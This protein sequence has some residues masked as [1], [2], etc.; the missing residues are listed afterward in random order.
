[1][2]RHVLRRGVEANVGPVLIAAGDREIADALAAE[3]N[4]V[5]TNPNL[6]SGSDRSFAA[7]LHFDPDGSYDVIVNL[8][9]DMPTISPVLLHKAISVLDDPEIDIVTL[10]TPIADVT[11]ADRAAVVKVAMEPTARDSVIG[12]A[13]YFSRWPI[14]YGAKNLLHHIGLYVYRRRALERFVAAQ[15][16]HLERIEKLEQLRALALGLTIGVAVVDAAPLGVDTL[17]DLEEARR[18]LA[19]GAGAMS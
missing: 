5:L 6:A 8:Q 10:A 11:E 12:R 15:P 7:L 17:E 1:M 13:I 3:A 19:P 2:I 4:V 14:P 16:S 18:R 9:G